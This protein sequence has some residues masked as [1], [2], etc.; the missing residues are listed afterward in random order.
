[1]RAARLVDVATDV[2]HRQMLALGIG[3][4]CAQSSAQVL[5]KA[6]EGGI[7]PAALSVDA[8]TDPG[9]H[10]AAADRVATRDC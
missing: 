8:V 4:L 3:Q 6:Q 7:R 2:N 9:V 1:M 10:I 5:T